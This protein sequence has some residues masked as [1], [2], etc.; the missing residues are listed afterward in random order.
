[1]TRK[2]WSLEDM[3]DQSGRTVVITG[4]NSGLGLETTRAFAGRGA[5]VIM[6]CRNLE[7]AARAE[8]DVRDTHPSASLEV[9]ALDLADLS[10]VQSFAEGILEDV[11][12]LDLLI[13]NAGIMAIP[14]RETAD[15]FEMQLGTNHLGH[16]ALTGRLLPRLLETGARTGDARVVSVSSTAHKMGRMHFDDLQ[17]RHGYGDWK[18]YGQ[19][20]LANLLFA[21]ELDRRLRAAASPVASLAAHPGYSD[22][23]LQAVGPRAHGSKIMGGVMKVLNAVAAQPPEMGALPTVRA[24]VDPSA[25]S[26]QYYGPR[27]FMERAGSPVVVSANDAAN[28]LGDAQR[29]WEVSEELTG[30]EYSF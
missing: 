2:G 12:Q 9:R 23:D 13:N 6:A 24:A 20:K 7:K 11:E 4:A 5:H 29:L 30:V 15:G 14:R 16:F 26:G 25:V 28:D 19:S 27:G 18:A 3:P 17:L 10:S 8:S 21:F 22:T 1:M